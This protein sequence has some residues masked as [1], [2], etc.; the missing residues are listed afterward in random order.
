MGP[1]VLI[2]SCP[3]GSQLAPG[4]FTP[5]LWLLYS[6]TSCGPFSAVTVASEHGWEMMRAIW[7]LTH[8]DE[9]KPRV[10][11]WDP[12]FVLGLFYFTVYRKHCPV[13]FYSPTHCL[14]K[15]SVAFQ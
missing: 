9:P 4:R 12:L 2:L 1:W 5:S 3:V 11:V 14:K 8:Q 13:S 6:K 7:R 15:Q 10:C